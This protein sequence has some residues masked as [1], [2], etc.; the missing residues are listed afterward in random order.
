MEFVF[1]LFLFQILG[2]KYNP[3][4][5]EHLFDLKLFT[6]PNTVSIK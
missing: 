5:P 2:L 3:H 1:M 6:L 4:F